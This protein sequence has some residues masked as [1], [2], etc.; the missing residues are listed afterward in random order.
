[1]PILCPESTKR[2][3]IEYS[4]YHIASL[5]HQLGELFDSGRDCD[6][7][8]AVVV[9]N[10]TIETLCA[11][12]VILSLVCVSSHVVESDLKKNNIF[13]GN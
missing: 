4:L 2:D 5:S 10:N 3:T 9:D 13:A 8:I 6:L 12:K 7:N 1:M 11:H